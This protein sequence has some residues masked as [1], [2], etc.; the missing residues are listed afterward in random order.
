MGDFDHIYNFDDEE[1]FNSQWSEKDWKLYIEKADL[2]ISLFLNLFVS[3]RNIV[4]HLDHIATQMGWAK[5]DTNNSLIRKLF[6]DRKDPTTIHTHPV[7]TVTRGL[8][9][10]LM[11]NWEIYLNTS[12]TTDV[13]LCWDYA[14]LLNNGERNALLGIS[15]MNAGDDALAICHFKNAL[16]ILNFTMDLIQKIPKETLKINVIF[17]DALT[18]CFDLREVW[19]KVM[20]SCKNQD[21]DEDEEEDDE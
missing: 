12:Q 15:C 9:H 17:H 4:N 20:E 6:S 14:Q 11:K 18:A 7:T 8:Y 10:F 2:Q 5:S 3:S 19:I 13:K 16:Q 1:F 21:S